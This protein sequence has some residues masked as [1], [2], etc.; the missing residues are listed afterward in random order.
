MNVF[1]VDCGLSARIGAGDGVRTRDLELGKI[2]CRLRTL[3]YERS[4]L[5][6]MPSASIPER[7]LIG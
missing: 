4:S 5:L 3:P 7:L 2:P 1:E 6:Q